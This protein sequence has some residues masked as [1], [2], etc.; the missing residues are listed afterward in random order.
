MAK[1]KRP[2]PAPRPE[3]IGP[4]LPTS[5]WRRDTYRALRDAGICWKAK[6]CGK[7]GVINGLCREHHAIVV[8]V[9]RAAAR[10]RYEHAKTHGLCTWDSCKR[11]QSEGALLCDEHVKVR[12]AI[13]ARMKARRPDEIRKM[14]RKQKRKAA[15]EREERG[16]CLRCNLPAVTRTLCAVHRAENNARAAAHR[17]AAGVE[18]RKAYACRLC[19][20]TGHDSRTC[21]NVSGGRDMLDIGEIATAGWCAWAA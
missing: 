6:S 13:G 5:E 1:A 12:R 10:R 21:P 4:L 7:R 16:K 11:P 19:R 3:F 17:R 15:R 14:Q 18:V 8:E 2:F 9:R 20:G